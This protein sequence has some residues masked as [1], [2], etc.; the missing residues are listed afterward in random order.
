MNVNVVTILERE[1]M[2]EMMNTEVLTKRGFVF[3][4]SVAVL[5]LC[6]VPGPRA[7]S[8]VVVHLLFCQLQVS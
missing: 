8:F 5:V 7:M 2:R 6:R 4:D 3:P 1:R